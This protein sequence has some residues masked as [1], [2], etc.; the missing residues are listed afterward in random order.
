MSVLFFDERYLEQRTQRSVSKWIRPQIRAHATFSAA[1]ESLRDFF[2]TNAVLA[3]PPPPPPPVVAPVPAAAIVGGSPVAAPVDVVEV[4]PVPLSR[5]CCAACF[6]HVG[7]GVDVAL[8]VTQQYV[9]DMSKMISGA[10]EAVH[11]VDVVQV[12][13]AHL[14]A[15]TRAVRDEWVRTDG[16]VYT[17]LQCACGA[18]L[19]VSMQAASVAH[20]RLVGCAWLLRTSVSMPTKA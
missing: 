10:A 4:P 9:C 8:S 16:L 5:V 2:A 18:F 12:T 19:G 15:N 17:V 6:R 1:M 20:T 14:T 13:E 3:R 7:S 11:S